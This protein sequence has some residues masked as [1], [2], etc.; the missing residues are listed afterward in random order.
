MDVSKKGKGL[1]WWVYLCIALG[2][3][4]LIGLL[5]ILILCLCKGDRE[6]VITARETDDGYSNPLR[7]PDKESKWENT[8]PEESKVPVTEEDD[9]VLIRETP[10]QE[11]VVADPPKT[12]RKNRRIARNATHFSDVEIDEGN[13]IEENVPQSFDETPSRRFR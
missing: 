13:E 8:H 1:P 6:E 7:A 2:C 3:L 4:L 5:V 9:V 11:D 10:P 12:S